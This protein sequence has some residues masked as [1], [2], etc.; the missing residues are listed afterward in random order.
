MQLISTALNEKKAILGVSIFLILLFA[1]LFSDII[2]PLDPNTQGDISLD[3]YLSPSIEHPF[4]TDKF[5]R[6][7][8]SRVLFGGRISLLIALSVVSI[9]VLF[10]IIY[11]SIAGYIG[12]R[13]DKIMMHVL[14]FLLAFPM[15]FLIITIIAIFKIMHWY[16]IPIIAFTS[17]METARL[18]RAEV[19]TIKEREYITAATGLGLSHFRILFR[20]ILPNCVSIIIVTIPLKI[21]EVILLESALSFLGIGIQP[22]TASWGSLINDGREVLMSAWWIATFPGL[23][24]TFTVLSF[25]LMSESIKKVIRHQ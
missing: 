18:I 21:A 7:V 3:R 22:P 14:D 11:G 9:S 17:W 16:L 25:N 8:F 1:S 2:W 20:H 5:G 13:T 15:I 19:L 24:I 10:G 6:D 12:G 23:F 4:G